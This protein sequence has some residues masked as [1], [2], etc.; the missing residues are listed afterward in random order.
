MSLAQPRSYAK[1]HATEEDDDHDHYGADNAHHQ[2]G[3]HFTIARFNGIITALIHDAGQE[4]LGEV[5]HLFH[6]L[7]GALESGGSDPT[8]AQLPRSTTLEPFVE[9]SAHVDASDVGFRLLRP[10]RVAITEIL[11]D[12]THASDL[13]D[14]K[15]R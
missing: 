8:V 10:L 5:V 3:G 11:V 1:V 12:R 4:H 7:L 14:V 2:A 9:F 13:E 15:F 6:L